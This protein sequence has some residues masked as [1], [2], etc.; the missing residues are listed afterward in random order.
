MKMSS[1]NISGVGVGE[2]LSFNNTRTSPSPWYCL[3]Y[4]KTLQE[5]PLL[6]LVSLGAQAAQNQT[7]FIPLEATLWHG[8]LHIV[9]KHLL[10]LL[11]SILPEVDFLGSQGKLNFRAPHLQMPLLRS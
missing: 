10:L 2:P 7:S 5:Y 4:N 11:F 1:A 6:Y 3:P 9:A 8:L